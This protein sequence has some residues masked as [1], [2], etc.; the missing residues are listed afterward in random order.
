MGGV[1]HSLRHH[2]ESVSVGAHS[3][4]AA[5]A[6]QNHEP[7]NE[8][9]NEVLIHNEPRRSLGGQVPRNEALRARYEAR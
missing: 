8:P 7:R 2:V 1:T 4:A 9:R 5:L 3:S 6:L